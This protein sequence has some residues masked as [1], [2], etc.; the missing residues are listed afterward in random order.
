MIFVFSRAKS[1]TMP[2]IPA[3]KTLANLQLSNWWNLLKILRNYSNI[4][5]LELF[6]E[7]SRSSLV[8][9]FVAPENPIPSDKFIEIHRV[10]DEITQENHKILI[11][12]SYVKIIKEFESEFKKKNYNYSKIIGA[13]SKKEREKNI[14]EFETRDDIK[15]FLISIKAGGVGLNLTA[16][17]Y[18]IIIDPWWNPAVESQAIN[19]A[20]RIGQKKNVIVYRFISKNTIE[21]K[22]KFLQ[23]KKQT[24]S[25]EIIDF[26]KDIKLNQEEIK[27]LFN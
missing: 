9:P 15:L 4:P 1:G 26:E 18:V 5:I 16:A 2:S 17:D 3:M 11:F 14:N 19:R 27:A 20:H 21:E 8:W 25:N 22:I 12:S 13:S 23:N 7:N 6:S 24:L 10:I